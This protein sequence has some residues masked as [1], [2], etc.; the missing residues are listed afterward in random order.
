M[1]PAAFDPDVFVK[2]PDLQRFPNPP[3]ILIVGAGSRGSAYARAALASTNSV[4]A[5]VAEPVAYKRA[6]FGQK[7][8][9][10]GGGQAGAGQQFEGWREWRA[11][12]E[13]RRERENDG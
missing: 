11:Y 7:Y 5:A 12:E 8:V 13:G 4:V 2:A 6:A 9:W 3:R 1:P 10:G